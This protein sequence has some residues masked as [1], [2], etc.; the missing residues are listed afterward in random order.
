[1][2]AYIKEISVLG[3][4]QVLRSRFSHI[5]GPQNEAI[6]EILKDQVLPS[7]EVFF[8]DGTGIF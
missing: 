4:L 2:H 1:M 5:M 7:V 3:L 6:L 8:P